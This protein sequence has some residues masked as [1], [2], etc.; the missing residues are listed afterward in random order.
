MLRDHEM[1]EG[2]ITNNMFV[3]AV[4]YAEKTD[5]YTYN[6]MGIKDPNKR[7]RNIVKGLIME[8]SFKALLDR[9]QIEYD[10]LG[11]THWMKKDRYDVG[12]D[13]RRYDVKGSM[14]QSATREIIDGDPKWL[15]DCSALVPVDQIDSKTL[16]DEDFYVFSMMTGHFMTD[17]AEVYAKFDDID[18]V[19]LIHSFWGYEWTKNKK[20][21]RRGKVRLE[22]QMEGEFNFRLGGQDE[23]SEFVAERV[24]IQP[25]EVLEVESQFYT[26]LFAQSAD[27]PSG[28]LRVGIE[29]EDIIEEID[30][31]NWSNIWPYDVSVYHVGYMSKGEF[32]RRAAEIP[33]YFSDV[34]QYAITLTPNR[35]LPVRE[36]NSLR[37]VI[38]LI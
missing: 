36:L 2:P 5:A 34:K 4:E 14:I 9:H 8:Q 16:T 32:K 3:V 23:H 24:I 33:P 25:G 17:I 11:H 31:D 7:I 27:R 12:I 20:W 35:V 22:S 10:L 26:V 6:R 29:G 38:G 18:P 19:Y 28:S 15:L 1:L 21:T 30:A 13:G 37:D